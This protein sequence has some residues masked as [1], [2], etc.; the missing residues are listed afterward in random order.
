LISSNFR[1]D[2]LLCKPGLLLTASQFDLLIASQN[3]ASREF[4]PLLSSKRPAALNLQMSREGLFLRPSTLRIIFFE[5]VKK[6]FDKKLKVC[7]RANNQ[8][9]REEVK[10]CQAESKQ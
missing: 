4:L 9:E 6:P 5:L 1:N 7:Y 8:Y 3:G 2:S 10:I